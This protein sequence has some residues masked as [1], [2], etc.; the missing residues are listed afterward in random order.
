M[1]QNAKTAKLT[2]TPHHLFYLLSRFEELSIA[3]GP[4]NIRLENIHTEVSQS[5]VSFLNK[6]QRS[7]GDGASIHSVSSVRSVMSGMTDLWSSFR[8]G[9]KDALSKSDKAKAALELDLK[10]LYSAFT[11]IPC[12]RLAPDHRAPL[13]S[14]Y[15]EFP[16]DTAVPLHSFKNLSALEIIDL[17]YRS[18]Y[19]W[20]RLSEQL[21]TLTLKRAHLEDPADLLTRI[22]LDD[23][24]KRRRRSAKSQQSPS[25]GW[26]S[27]SST[28]PVHTPNQANSL[29]AP[30][31]PVMDTAFGTSTSPKSHPMIRAGSEGAKIRT[32]AGSTSP[33]RPATKHGHRRGQS[34]QIRRTGSASSESSDLSRNGSTSNLLADVLSPSKWRFLRHL[35]L[36]ENSLTS[37]SAASLAPVANSLNSLDL[38]SN[39]L[40]EIPDGVASLVA[41]RALNL[42]HCMIESLHSLTRNP[43]PAITVLTLRGNRLRSLAG[44]ERLLSLERLDLRDNNL[45]DPTEIA[46][47]TSLPE[48][49]EI[50]VSGNPFVNTHSGYRV[51]IMNLFRRTPGYSEDIIIDGR[52]PGYTERKQLVDRVAEPQ[53]APVVRS[54]QA[55]ESTFVQ[56]SATI[57]K[58]SH[59]LTAFIPQ[60]NEENLHINKFQ[61]KETDGGTHHKKLQR[62]K[63]VDISVDNPFTTDGLGN[64]GGTTR[65]ALPVQPIQTPADHPTEVPVDQPWRLDSGE[66]S[67]SSSLQ[68]PPKH[69]HSPT[70]TLVQP[71][72]KDRT[73]DEEFC[74]QQLEVLRQDVGHN[75]LT[76][77]GEND[78]DNS[79][80]DFAHSSGAGLDHSPHISTPPITR[81][82]TQ[83]ILSGHAL[84]G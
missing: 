66:Q 75:W 41:L 80:K 13:I 59:D 2:L 31:S 24:D 26:T 81:S 36:P 9:S 25:L 54:S 62:R 57:S 23:I 64:P 84:S 70:S 69:I 76:V 1:S 28:Q 16:F 42:S 46:R 10:Y 37:V 45:T 19:G 49:R 21:R 6:P 17:D 5:Y 53:A 55:D 71:S 52:G 79:H 27:S 40:T 12:L 56:K 73:M 77:L 39:L 43:L 83:A 60:D 34:R 51:V 11:K 58:A 8:I 65:S 63:I 20:D 30:G 72:S 82:N 4:M 35:G 18:F 7:R 22:V 32:R 47:L 38:S 61:S 33:T 67:G 50:W 14:G 48:I 78:W 15:E 68:S 74:R 3:V 29:S 44:I